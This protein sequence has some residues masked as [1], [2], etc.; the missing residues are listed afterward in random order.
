MS[1][2]SSNKTSKPDRR[3]NDLASLVDRLGELK[4]LISDLC[5]E[6]KS[7][8]DQL[9]D[10]RLPCVDGCTFRASISTSERISLDSEKVKMFLSPAQIVQCQKSS[11]VTTVRV[12][13]RIKPT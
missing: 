13:A 5:N 10:T 1:K 12:T 6:E 4:A 8:K 7:I 9:I 11:T 2:A 3:E